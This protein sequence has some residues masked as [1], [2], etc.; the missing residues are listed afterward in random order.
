[1]TVRPVTLT[2]IVDASHRA[3]RGL[4]G[5]GIVLHATDRPR[6]AGPII[7]QIAEAHT[8]VSA[9]EIELFAVYRALEIA[10]ERGFRRVKVRSDYN[11]MR[12]RLKADHRAGRLG[13]SGTLHGRTLMLARTFDEVVFAYQPRRRNGMAHRLARSASSG[14]VAST[15][16]ASAP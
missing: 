1:M 16:T 2:A 15:S 7:D 8:D 6:R 5:I 10:R 12:R 14:E 4:T 13:P 11:Y 3:E 9:S